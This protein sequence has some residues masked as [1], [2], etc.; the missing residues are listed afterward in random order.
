MLTPHAY[1]DERMS[2]MASRR[3]AHHDQVNLLKAK[4][5]ARLVDDLQARYH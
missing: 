4:A 2:S 5:Y 1:A 3:T